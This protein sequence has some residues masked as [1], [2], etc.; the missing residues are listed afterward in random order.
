QLQAKEEY[1][2]QTTR[3]PTCGHEL[4]IPGATS[5]EAAAPAADRPG[6]WGDGDE[7]ADDRQRPARATSGKAIASLVL[8][9]PSV[10][11]CF[12]LTGIPALILGLIGLKDIN[13]SRGRLGGRGMAITG[14]VLGV[15]GCVLSVSLLPVALLVPA[16]QKVR[17][18]AARAQSQNNL[19]QLGL[20]IHNYHDVYGQFP[21]AV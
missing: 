4:P 11:L 5:F 6:R 2:G 10:F 12:L 16:V 3:C 15:I 18:A 17:G 20:A 13:D 21:P 7:Q 14:I 19:K 1:A 8:G 9:I